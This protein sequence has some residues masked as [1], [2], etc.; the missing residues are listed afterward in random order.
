M[1]SQSLAFLVTW[2]LTQL[3]PLAATRVSLVELAAAEKERR[4][5][6]R[7]EICS[8]TN[9]DI[10]RLRSPIST[11]TKVKTEKQ[12]GPVERFKVPTIDWEARVDLARQQVE[13]AVQRLH[14]LRL[15]HNHLRNLYLNAEIETQRIRLEEQLRDLLKELDDAE[16]EESNARNLW[17]TTAR[18]ARKAGI[19]V[20]SE[21]RE[22]V[23]I[24]P[25]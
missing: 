8:Y 20:G 6:I 7:Q 10:S 3:L 1:G 25:F 23:E 12:E 24:V 17:V 16:V 15:R 2:V 4:L 22:S 13:T 21:P 11:S 9:L 19:Q 18:E 5:A 14:M